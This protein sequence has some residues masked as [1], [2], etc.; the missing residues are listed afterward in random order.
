M[1]EREAP[2]SF[3]GL[4]GCSVRKGQLETPNHSVYLKKR[5]S[6]S[7]FLAEPPYTRCAPESALIQPALSGRRHGDRD[8]QD[9]QREDKE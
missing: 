6:S 7:P 2:S 3:V 4:Q 9:G 1:S 8:R 5:V